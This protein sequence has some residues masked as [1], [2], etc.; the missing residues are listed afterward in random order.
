MYIHTAA[1]TTKVIRRLIG[2]QKL[3]EEEQDEKA[4]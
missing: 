2:K 1:N 4:K 3:T